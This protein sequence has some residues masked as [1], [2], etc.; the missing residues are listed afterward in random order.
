[1]NHVKAVRVANR[2]SQ[3]NR[4]VA[5]KAASRVR[6]AKAASRANSVSH[7]SRANRATTANVRK[8]PIEVSVVTVAIV[9]SAVNAKSL[10]RKLLSKH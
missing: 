8:P 3:G 5:V 9:R 4:V 2:A 6:H 10:S 7:A 1:M